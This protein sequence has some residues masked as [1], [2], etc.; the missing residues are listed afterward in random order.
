MP[1]QYTAA[2]DLE[3]PLSPQDNAYEVMH[4]IK[5][6]A[7]LFEV[8]SRYD[9][10]LAIQNR[11][12]Y[13][14]GDTL[15]LIVP[16]MI[17]NG[18]TEQD[19]RKASTRAQ[20][21]DGAKELIKWLT[22]ETWNVHIIST[23]YEQHAY[24]VAS[25]L[26]VEREKVHCTRFPLDSLS[27][28]LEEGDIALIHEIQN[29]ILSFYYNANDAETSTFGRLATQL[30]E[31]F[32]EIAPRTRIKA[33][34]DQI[35]V[36]GGKRKVQ[37]L[38]S[39]IGVGKP[40]DTAVIGDSITD[41]KML[42]EI[43]SAG[44]IS[45]AFNG[46]SYALPYA[47]IGMACADIRPLYLVLTAFREGGLKSAFDLASLWE[48]ERREFARDPRLVPNHA[49]R[50]ELARFFANAHDKEFPRLS[51]LNKRNKEQLQ[52]IAAIHAKFRSLIRGQETAQLG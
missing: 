33:I 29:K 19:V 47:N 42:Q 22:D 36:V 51:L 32:F 31:F 39:A 9:D 21:V 40:T 46:N 27:E 26:E 34:F 11:P 5:E 38:I 2:F 15:Q 44:G 8:L 12:H 17:V 28:M 6:G 41:Y 48:V 1:H 52:Q 25:K 35:M 50:P 14:P 30:D 3:G 13:E 45:I 10:Y 24:N 43:R 4:S 37:A 7:A 20:L 16:F 23:S 18:I 49:S